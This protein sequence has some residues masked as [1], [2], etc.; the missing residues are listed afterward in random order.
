M[1]S[2]TQSQRILRRSSRLGSLPLT[3]MIDVVFLLLI[4]FLVTS[5]F[6]QEEHKLPSTLQT[7]GGGV[8]SQDLQP[9]IIQIIMQENKPVFV[10]GD[11]MV[12]DGPALVNF[13]N[14]LPKEPGIAIKSTPD[15]PISAIALALQSARDAGFQKRSYV[16]RDE[17]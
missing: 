8:Q 10:I 7:E 4:F 12:Q 2:K 6:A 14:R 13:L 16:P 11:V 3:S 15:A 9:Q 1:T 5:N 17:N